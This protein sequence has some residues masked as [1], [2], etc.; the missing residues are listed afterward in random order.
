MHWSPLQ[1]TENYLVVHVDL[2]PDDSLEGKAL[3]WLDEAELARRALFVHATPRRH[4]TLCRAAL[5]TLLCRKLDCRNSDLSFE[6]SSLGKPFARN[7]GKPAPIAF[8]LSHSGHH[9]LIAVAPRGRIGVDVEERL[10]D[11]DLDSYSRTLLAPVERA[12]FEKES[13]NRKCELFYRLWTMKEALVKAAGEGL[14]L[15]TSKFE[16]PP[17]MVR[18]E[19]SGIFS[20]P[21]S[22]AT[23]WRLEYIGNDRYAAAVARELPN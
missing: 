18:G 2:T 15:D 12:F 23:R 1:K 6:V 8:N 10:P 13:G 11:R 9:G 16:L 19:P 20:F 7:R 5:R 21:D 22:S 3:D 14:S 4:F 17:T